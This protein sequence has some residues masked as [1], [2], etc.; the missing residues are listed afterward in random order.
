MKKI[1]SLFLLIF[2]FIVCSKEAF[3]QNKYE[4]A[5]AANYSV[6]KYNTS[7]YEHFTFWADAAGKPVEVSYSMKNRDEDIKFSYEGKTVDGKGFKVKA[8]NGATSS[9]YVVGNNLRVINDKTKKAKI[10]R[11]EYEG[12]VEGRGTFCTPCVQEPKEAAEFIKKYFI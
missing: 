6:G 9:I 3:S 10:F 12:P 11:W 1:L 4:N 5:K 2:A 8:P 7:S